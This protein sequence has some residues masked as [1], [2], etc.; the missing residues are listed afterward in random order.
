M[1]VYP[2]K[3]ASEK[4]WKGVSLCESSGGVREALVTDAE[5]AGTL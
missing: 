4:S 1:L 3:R 2:Q 5:W